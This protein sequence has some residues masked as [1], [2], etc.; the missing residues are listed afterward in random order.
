MSSRNTHTDFCPRVGEVYANAYLVGEIVEVSPRITA[1]NGKEY[2]RFGI[3]VLMITDPTHDSAMSLVCGEIIYRQATPA[4]RADGTFN[5]L[6][7]Y[8]VK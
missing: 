4:R 3:E 5:K 2:F 7:N 1:Q 8:G 6:K